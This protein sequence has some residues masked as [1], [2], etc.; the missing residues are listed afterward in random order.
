MFLR[1][2]KYPQRRQYRFKVIG[3]KGRRSVGKH[4]EK[5]KLDTLFKL[6]N[7]L[8][9]S[10][11]TIQDFILCNRFNYFCT[12]TFSDAKLDRFNYD[13]CKKAITE[14]FKNFRNR[15]APAFK[16]VIVPEQHKDGAWHFHG[17][18]SGMPIEEFSVPETIM[19]RNR[20]T[21]EVEEVPNR[22]GYV[23]WE[24]YSKRF[25]FFDCSKIKHYEAC[26]SYV[27]KYITK[28]LVDFKKGSRI[29]FASQD[30]QTPNLIMDE[31][32]IPFPANLKS[33]YD[34]QFVRISWATYQ[35]TIQ[36]N[37]VDFFTGDEFDDDR[38]PLSIEMQFLNRGQQ[39]KAIFEPLTYT[40]LRLD[41]I[42]L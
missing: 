14:F 11:R 30:L 8:C 12:F 2:Y 20:L 36:A 3:F 29:F 21:N 25:G 24:R 42:G 33:T 5:K 4:E 38:T 26:A 17:V 32:E 34:D 1:V 19:Y 7:S 27:S 22:K 9:R 41:A 35:Q 13:V 31:D 18:I 6:D 28:A 37:L 10:R 40:Q 39:E 16:Y 15:Y 23:R